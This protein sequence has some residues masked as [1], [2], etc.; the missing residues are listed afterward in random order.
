MSQYDELD[1]LLRDLTRE[2]EI[3]LADALGVKKRL[4]RAKNEPDLF[5]NKLI[6]HEFYGHDM[7]NVFRTPYDPDYEEIV[8]AVAEK[9]KAPVGCN[10]SVEDM[11]GKIVIQ[12]IK[13]AKEAIVKKKGKSAWEEV[14]QAVKDRL[15]ALVKAGKLKLEDLDIGDMKP[16]LIVTALLAGQLAG[17]SLFLVSNLV[18][19]SIATV[20]GIGLVMA[21]SAITVVTAVLLG[22]AGWILAGFWAV[23][24]L[25]GTKWE[26]T[27]KA[28]L[29]I[30]ILR[31]SKAYGQVISL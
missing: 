23:Y 29:L 7:L 10:D 16:G 26:E 31:S 12:V 13:S 24:N 9:V 11:E 4:P 25:G 30:A 15:E 1:N 8:K 20:L 28:V 18:L 27:I 14:E 19:A 17:P 3:S 5:F 6:R 21:G 2:E 22:P